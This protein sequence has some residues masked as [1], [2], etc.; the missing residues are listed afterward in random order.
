MPRTKRHYAPGCVWHLT[1]NCHNRE[2]LPRFERDHGHW[3]RV[4]D[5]RAMQTDGVSP[6]DNFLSHVPVL[7]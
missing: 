2:F 6:G 7:S 5:M 1:H 3:R 4:I